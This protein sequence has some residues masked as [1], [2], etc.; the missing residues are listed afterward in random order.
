MLLLRAS[1]LP[2][3]L[4]LLSLSLTVRATEVSHEE[5]LPPALPVAQ[6]TTEPAPATSGAEADNQPLAPLTPDFTLLG[7]EI[8]AGQFRTLFWSPGQSFASIDTPVPVLVARGQNPGPV[9]CLTGALHGD[10]LNWDG[11]AADVP[12]EPAQHER[13]RHRRAHC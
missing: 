12:A 13:Y 9:L 4:I 8:A 6:D 7:S 1:L 2:S 5:D 3:L 10:E 11:A